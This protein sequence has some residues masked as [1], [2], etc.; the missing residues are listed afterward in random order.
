[1]SDSSIIYDNYKHFNKFKNYPPSSSYIAGFIDGD[2]SIFIRKIKDGFQTGI[3]ISQCRTNILQIIRYHFG[4]TIT[5]SYKYIY[6]IVDF[7]NKDTINNNRMRN[8][9]N[10]II[11]SNEY[12]FILQYLSNKLI[13]KDYYYQCL[14]KISKLVNIPNTYDIKYNIYNNYLKYDYNDINIDNINDRLNIDYICGLFDAEGCIYINRNNFNK[15]YISIVQKQ[16][17]V[18]IYKI[19][20]YLK[21]GNISEEYRF[22]IYNK[23]DCLKFIEITKNI[24]IVKFNQLQA[25]ETFLTTNDISIKLKM[26]NICNFEKHTSEDYLQNNYNNIGN[27]LFIEKTKLHN[28]KLLILKQIIK[29]NIYIEKSINMMGIKNHNYGKNL[30]YNIKS[31]ISLSNIKSKRK[32]DDNTIIQVLNLIKQGYKNIY[33][34]NMLNL[35]RHTITRIKNGK[36]NIIN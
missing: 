24:C 14:C 25:F 30:S 16:C 13:I 4:G 9:Y 32:I 29:K 17:P 33:I 20:D 7:F 27:K 35:P 1:M 11:R 15:Y 22:K 31:K 2:G 18:I 10:L 12:L 8:Q 28:I 19:L 6:K 5:C 26:Y 23:S 36:I 34:Q 3:S 21:F